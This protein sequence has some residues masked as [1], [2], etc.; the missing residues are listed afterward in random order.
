MVD[1]VLAPDG[2]SYERAAIERWFRTKRTSPQT[3]APV[4]STA[5]VPNI[6]LRG[7]IES[8]QTGAAAFH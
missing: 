3:N 1:P 6:A 7:L 4:A 8:F 5:L 2:F